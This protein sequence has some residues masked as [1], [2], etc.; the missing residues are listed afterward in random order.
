MLAKVGIIYELGDLLFPQVA[1]LCSGIN[2]SS[3]VKFGLR[4][5]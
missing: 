3:F 5:E 4:L 2:S 1:I